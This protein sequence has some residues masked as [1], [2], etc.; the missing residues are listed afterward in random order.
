MTIT[1]SRHQELGLYRD[2]FVV[3]RKTIDDSMVRRARRKL[4]VSLGALSSR[5]LSVTRRADLDKS[6]ASAKALGRDPD[7]LNLFNETALKRI[8]GSLLGACLEPIQ[9]AQVATNF[10]QGEN[11]IVNESGYPVKDT[12]HNGWCGHLDGLWNGASRV[13]AIDAVLSPYRRSRWY[14]DPSTNGCYRTYPGTNS[15]LQNFTALVGVALSDQLVEGAGNLGVLRGAHKKMGEFFQAQRQAGGPLGPDGPGWPRENKSA[16]N[17]HGLRH[18]PDAIRQA[19][20]GHAVT[21]RDGQLWPKPTLLK[22]KA[23]DAVSIHYAAPHAA[24]KV[25]EPDP[26]FMIYFR[27]TSSCRQEHQLMVFPE[28]LCDIWLEWPGMQATV[29]EQEAKSF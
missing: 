3:L 7:I 12:P 23:G 20:S 22:M 26:R 9:R 10:P 1:L 4:Y 28:A 17:G 18:Y 16:P 13:P 2:G 24:T 27:I 29:A 25:I 8:L 21:T 15:N 14:R 5:A 6:I 11:D 19:F